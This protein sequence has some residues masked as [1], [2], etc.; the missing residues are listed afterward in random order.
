MW[1]LLGVSGVGGCGGGSGI[2]RA[3]GVIAGLGEFSTLLQTSMS[4]PILLHLLRDQE[5]GNRI[6][7]LAEVYTQNR[8]ELVFRVRNPLSGHPNY[9]MAAEAGYASVRRTKA[10][11]SKQRF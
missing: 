4:S 7:V 2:F 1:L 11:K 5:R 10:R 6:A 9:Q 3:C 8:W